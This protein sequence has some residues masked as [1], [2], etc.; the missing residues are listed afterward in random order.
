MIPQAILAPMPPDPPAQEG[1]RCAPQF[2]VPA[3]RHARG[4]RAVIVRTG[5]AA[6][7][8][9]LVHME[10]MLTRL[11]TLQIGD[12]LHT[13]TRA[14]DEDEANRLVKPRG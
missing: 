4:D 11:Q 3:G 5:A 10:A 2:V 1:P 9:L 6:A 12:E 14:G 7:A 13:R 8:V